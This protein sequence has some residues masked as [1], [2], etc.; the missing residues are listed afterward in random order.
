MRQTIAKHLC[1]SRNDSSERDEKF[2]SLIGVG[3]DR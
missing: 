2:C 1:R 3:K